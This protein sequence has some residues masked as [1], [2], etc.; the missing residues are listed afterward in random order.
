MD[1]ERIGEHES[2]AIKKYPRKFVDGTDWLR[3]FNPAPTVKLLDSTRFVLLPMGQARLTSAQEAE[4]NPP[5]PK[6][7]KRKAKDDNGTQDEA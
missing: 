7:A 5:P 1:D 2:G 4:L 6:P 3:G